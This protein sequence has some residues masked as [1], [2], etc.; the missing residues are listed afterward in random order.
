MSKDEGEVQGEAWCRNRATRSTKDIHDES[1]FANGIHCS[2]YHYFM[3][4]IAWC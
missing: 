4:Y 3:D 1:A 2:L